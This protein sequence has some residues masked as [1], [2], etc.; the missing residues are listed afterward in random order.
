MQGK[1]KEKKKNRTGLSK[2][3]ME[4]RFLLLFIK[5]VP[6]GEKGKS[7]GIVLQDK[8]KKPSQLENIL[9]KMRRGTCCV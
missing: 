9:I 3:E 7:G 5:W 1:E 2:A 6:V 4:I 8:R